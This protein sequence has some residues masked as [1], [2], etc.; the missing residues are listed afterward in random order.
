MT[1]NPSW[2]ERIAAL[3]PAI[4]R[5]A[6]VAVIGL[7]VAVTGKII[8]DATVDLIVNVV[9]VLLTLLAAIV[10]RPAVTPNAKVIALKP[11]PVNQPDRIE[12]GEA[13]VTQNQIND[14]VEAAVNTPKAA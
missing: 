14:V 4:V 9:L 11:D 3:D 1:E 2:L 10:I 6:I 13:V 5:G 12:S 8:D 7:V